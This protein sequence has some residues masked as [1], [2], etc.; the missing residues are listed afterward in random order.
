MLGKMLGIGDKLRNKIC[1]I[2]VFLLFN[3]GDRYLLNNFIND[4]IIF[5]GK[6]V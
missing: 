1:V 5:I 2:F 4:I 3:D 6:L